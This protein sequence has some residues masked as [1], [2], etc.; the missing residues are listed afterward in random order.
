VLVD[1]EA[2]GRDVLLYDTT[3]GLIGTQSCVADSGS[4]LGGRAT[5]T[6][7]VLEQGS[8]TLYAEH[9]DVAGNTGRSAD[10]AVE[11]D[12]EPPTITIAIPSCG[13]MLHISSPYITDVWATS[14]DFPLTLT[15][16]DSGG[17]PIGS[18]YVVTTGS[19]GSAHF[20]GVQL[21]AGTVTLE[22]C[23]VDSHGQPGCN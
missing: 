23:A 11:V 14:S 17:A 4:S 13:S 9:T 19:G 3:A 16:Y 20:T 22:A 18:P 5:F 2:V 1:C 21:A 15:V 8:R 7:Q 12:T 10:V 6:A